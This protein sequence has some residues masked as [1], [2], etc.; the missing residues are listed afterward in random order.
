MPRIL[1][2]HGYRRT[3]AALA[4]MGEAFKEAGY[5]VWIPEL[6]TT[7][8]R[9]K[10]CVV[11]LEEAWRAHPWSLDDAS[12]L[13]LVGHSYGGLIARGWVASRIV[14]GLESLTCLG[15]SHHGTFLADFL[16]ALGARKAEPPLLE[17]R[18]PGPSIA[19]PLQGFPA[20]IHLIAGSR[21][22]L[23]WGRLLLPRNSD[24]RLSVKSALAQ[25]PQGTTAHFPAFTRRTI[26][27]L[28]HHQLMDHPEAFAAVLAGIC[29]AQ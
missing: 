7:H 3:G 28:D 24:G 26:L 15:S 1:L 10:G 2:L 29:D 6:P 17:F 11:A 5:E 21:N 13:H 14:P 27:A 16:L 9:L 20:S 19:P 23:F 4:H 22:A 25:D 8:L 12:P 18:T